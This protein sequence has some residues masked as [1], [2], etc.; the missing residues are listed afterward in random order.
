MKTLIVSETSGGEHFIVPEGSHTAVCCLVADLGTQPGS[1]Y[2]PK[3]QV[4][5]GF[6][7]PGVTHTF[8]EDAGPEEA[9]LSKFFT[10]SLNDSANLRKFLEGW[11]SKGFTEEERQG[12]DL[13]KLL[14]VPA[15][16]TV[17]HQTNQSGQPR[18]VILHASKLPAGMDAPK[19]Q[20]PSRSFAFAEP[21]T[22]D[23]ETLPGFVQTAIK[24]SPEYAAW[25]RSHDVCDLPAVTTEAEQYQTSSYD[26]IPF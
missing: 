10:R 2:G 1:R 7:L 19:S 16:L 4:L 8:D 6:A 17:A 12:F 24:Q 20:M 21:S 5:I 25:R 22:A 13:L 9:M 15:L 18:A 11:R 26:E 23:F 14:G 3:H